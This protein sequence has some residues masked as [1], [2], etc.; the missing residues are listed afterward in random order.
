MDKNQ[1]AV[2]LWGGNF[3]R[4]RWA[5]GFGNLEYQYQTPV[6]GGSSMLLLPAESIT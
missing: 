2:V 6:L 4:D 5:L 1:S 3:R